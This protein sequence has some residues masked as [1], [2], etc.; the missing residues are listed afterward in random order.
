MGAQRSIGPAVRPTRR[1]TALRWLAL[2]LLGLFLTLSF[3]FILLPWERLRAPLVAQLEAATDLTV[4][5]DRIEPTLLLPAPALGFYG[6]QLTLPDGSLFEIEEL[7]LRPAFSLRWL[8]GTPALR[9]RLRSHQGD[10]DGTFFG[11]ATPGARGRLSNLDLALFAQLWLPMDEPAAEGR[12][13]AEFDLA[14]RDGD[15]IGEAAW[16]A[17]DGQL[18]LESLGFTLPYPIPYDLFSGALVLKPE[19]EIELLELVL[20]GGLFDARGA[21][22]I[23]ALGGRGPGK[24]DILLALLLREKSLRPLVEQ[25]GIELDAEGRTKVAISGSPRA[26]RFTPLP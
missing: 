16:D 23:L 24:I 13:D 14:L 11:G 17:R 5:I 19:G 22:S 20:D 4:R 1:H 25:F 3:V 18:D 26:P 6:T 21:G 15:W 2:A 9:F 10:G 7:Q 12:L 8:Q